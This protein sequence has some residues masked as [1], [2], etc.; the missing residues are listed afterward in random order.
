MDRKCLK[1]TAPPVPLISGNGLQRNLRLKVPSRSFP[2]PAPWGDGLVGFLHCTPTL[3]PH[4]HPHIP[5][6]PGSAWEMSVQKKAVPK[7][8]T[9]TASS[10]S[11]SNH[12]GKGKGKFHMVA[13]E[14]VSQQSSST[15]SWFFLFF[16]LSILFEACTK[17]GWCVHMCFVAALSLHADHKWSNDGR[18]SLGWLRCS[19][20]GCGAL[21]DEICG[22]WWSLLWPWN[23][24]FA[25]CVDWTKYDW[26]RERIRN[27]WAGMKAANS[28]GMEKVPVYLVNT[29]LLKLDDSPTSCIILHTSFIRILQYWLGKSI[30]NHPHQSSIIN[31]PHP[32]VQSCLISSKPSESESIINNQSMKIQST[33]CFQV[34]KIFPWNQME[35]SINHRGTR[36]STN[37]TSAGGQPSGGL[38][39]HGMGY[40]T[41][42]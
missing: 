11:E 10:S 27:L 25:C 21:V 3:D 14:K 6:Q 20:C 15:Y 4:V 9:G 18:K 2:G 8:A 34:M 42:N 1:T 17:N 22:S 41:W 7:A 40:P 35:P 26:S 38:P 5:I 37:P 13:K 23:S 30:R 19:C 31:H 32:L 12:S 29:Y 28:K 16:S 33:C 39:P 24:I 36:S